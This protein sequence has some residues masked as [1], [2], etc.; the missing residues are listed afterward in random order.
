MAAEA[1]PPSR[2]ANSDPQKLS[3]SSESP[4]SVPPLEAGAEDSTEIED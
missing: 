2:L 1:P 4:L 3:S